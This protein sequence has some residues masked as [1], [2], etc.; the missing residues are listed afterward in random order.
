[1]SEYT[2]YIGNKNYSSWSLRPW[3][4]MTT[5]GIPFEEKLIL[6]FDE[7]W[8]QN[9]EAVSPSSCVPVLQHGDLTVWETMAILEYLAESHPEAKLWPEDARARA[10]ARAVANE[11][12]AGFVSLRG[13]MPMNIRKSLPGKGRG[14]G[15]D[16][17][18]QRVTEIW[19]D[20]R[21]RF[22]GDGKFLFGDFTIADAMYAPVISRFTTYAVD[23]DVVSRAYMNAV[24]E[25]P[26]MEA[27]TNDALKEPWVVLED[28]IE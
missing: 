25:L 22:G 1:M 5:A 20:C 11:M 18:I 3:L 26:A 9:V 12:H 19:N 15:V 7:D 2:L 16:R 14:D 17:D 28:E 21:K 4:A 13:A 6:L 10:V 8:K 27:W 24:L 23:V